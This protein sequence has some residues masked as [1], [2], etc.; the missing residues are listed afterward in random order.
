MG[1]RLKQQLTL[2]PRLQQSVKLL[3][4]SAL[5]CVQELHQAIAQNP[6]LEESAETPE[7]SQAEE[8]AAEDSAHADLDFS[9]SGA[10][11]GGDDTPDWT[12][13]T[14]SPSTLHDSLRE[15]LLLLGLT[16][17]D[18]VLAN[19]IV[20]ALDEDGF[21]RQPLEEFAA[22][23]LETNYP[24]HSISFSTRK[25]TLRGM[26]Y[27]RDP[28]SEAKLVRCT[29]GAILD[30]I[31]DIRPDSSTYRRWQEFELSSVNGHQLYIPKGFAHGFQTLSN[32]VEVNY[33]IS[34]PYKSEAAHG[35]RYNDPAFGISWPLP[36]TEISEK[37]SDWPDFSQ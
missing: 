28:H 17:R 13:W 33:L 21:L 3:Q 19:L 8:S 7:S 24:Q 16:E 12:E 14:A 25:G 27:Q 15:Q 31:I 18:Y 26:H 2:T 1:L 29:Q 34:A 4:L 20:D 30:V 35:I 32:D 22:H 36:V 10:G 23:G 11:G 9:G 6:F 5:E 37:D